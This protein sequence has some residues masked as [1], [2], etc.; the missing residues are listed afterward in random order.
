M[1]FAADVRL[2]GLGLSPRAKREG[3]RSIA[4]RLD[5]Q[6]RNWNP[7]H[8]RH[9]SKGVNGDVLRAA[10]DPAYIGA[11]NPCRQG[12]L[13]LG[14]AL[15]H[16]EF[17][18]IPAYDLSRVHRGQEGRICGLTIDGLMV[19]YFNISLYMDSSFVPRRSPQLNF[20]P[21]LKPHHMIG[22]TK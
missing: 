15:V 7:E 20:P 22:M 10:L 3:L 8:R 4:L 5:Q 21:N 18:E 12:K 16:P 1:R 19:P 17:S 9:E 6:V 11:V 2:G 13:L 14:H